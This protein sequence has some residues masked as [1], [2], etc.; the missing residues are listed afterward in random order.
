[1][2]DEKIEYIGAGMSI[3]ALVVM[4]VVLVQVLRS[5]I[6]EHKLLK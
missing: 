5:E 1:M 2:P 4:C 3:L 6:L